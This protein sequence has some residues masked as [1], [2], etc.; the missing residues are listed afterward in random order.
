MCRLN[1]VLSRAWIYSAFQLALGANKGR[2]EYLERYVRPM[3]GAWVLDIGCGPADILDALPEVHYVGIDLSPEYI[4]A[5]QTRYGSRGEFVCRSVTEFAVERPGTFDIVMAN[6][7]LH[8][9][10]DVEAAALFEAARRALKPSGR[11][12]TIDGCF[13][14]NQS[15]IARWMLRND[16]GEFVRRPEEYVQLAAATFASVE[17]HVRHNLPRIPYTHLIMICTAGSG[18]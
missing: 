12:V 14:P 4:Q 7:V 18:V 2:T 11:L 5:A 8:H 16:R 17:Q 13:V 10:N 6:G 1:A 15:R 3:P 9:L